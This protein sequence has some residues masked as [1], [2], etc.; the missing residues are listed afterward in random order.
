MKLTKS[1]YFLTFFYIS[2]A[3]WWVFLFL[4]GQKDSFNNYSF[5]FI[6]GL[7]PLMGGIFGIVE[8]KKWGLFASYASWKA[9]RLW[10]PL[11]TA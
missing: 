6:Y 4:S 11:E 3:I 2:V 7:L 10:D 8:A 9:Y 1:L 5:V